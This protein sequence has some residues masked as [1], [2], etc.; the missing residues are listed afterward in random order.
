MTEVTAD[1]PAAAVD[2]NAERYVQSI[3]Q[4]LQAA[5]LDEVSV[6]HGD[7]HATTQD[8]TAF[9]Q[10]IKERLDKAGLNEVHVVGE[11][12]RQSVYADLAVDHRGDAVA[13]Q[14]FMSDRPVRSDE[15]QVAEMPLVL[16]PEQLA[17]LRKTGPVDRV[18]E[19][20]AETGEIEMGGVVMPDLTGSVAP[21][22]PDFVASDSP[23]LPDAPAPKSRSKAKTEPVNPA[24][25]D[26]ASDAEE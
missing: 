23:G 13:A 4:R 22:M 25:V 17:A 3:E 18:L 20:D 21:P 7:S 5:G 10:A 6:V 8:D 12:G 16:S 9:A 2:A 19:R 24:P 14:A 26:T 1:R 11:D 15:P